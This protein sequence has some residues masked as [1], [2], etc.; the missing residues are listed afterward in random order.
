MSKLVYICLRNPEHAAR[1][2][3]SLKAS[4]T[5]WM[6]D[7]LAPVS[8]KV[9]GSKGIAIGIF[10]PTDLVRISDLSVCVGYLVNAVNSAQWRHARSGRP[11]GAYALFRADDRHVE[12]LADTL[13]SRT[14]W[15]FKNDDMFVA[16]TSQR[17]IVSLLGTFSFNSDV[18]DPDGCS[19]P[20]HWAPVFRGIGASNTW[21]EP[22]PSRW[23]GIPGH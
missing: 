15:Y 20:G 3:R 23:T 17:A 19:R 7:N 11:D 9:L 18:G 4:A 13:A 21:G 22:H 1:L 16:S 12:V 5:V 10:N 8:P 14:V 2:T 6:P